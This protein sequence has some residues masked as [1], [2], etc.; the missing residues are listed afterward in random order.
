M[1]FVEGFD[2]RAFD[3]WLTTD[4]RGA[5]LCGECGCEPRAPGN[6]YCEDCRLWVNARLAREGLARARLKT[7]SRIERM[8]AGYREAASKL[9]PQMRF[10][11]SHRDQCRGESF[12]DE[13]AMLRIRGR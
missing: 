6:I 12:C 2:G 1:S 11:L 5:D 7:P 13:C 8:R 10:A 9:T 3:A 4:P